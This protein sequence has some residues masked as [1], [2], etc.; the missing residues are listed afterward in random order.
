MI[1]LKT[2]RTEIIGNNDCFSE[3]HSSFHMAL[4]GRAL[5]SNSKSEPQGHGI[6]ADNC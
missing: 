4:I 6:L 3:L 5:F 2:I 1:I